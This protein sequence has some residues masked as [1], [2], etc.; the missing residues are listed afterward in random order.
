MTG[1][2]EKRVDHEHHFFGSLAPNMSVGGDPFTLLV[3]LLNQGKRL[4][5]EVD[6]LIQVAI[7]IVIL[8]VA[9]RGSLLGMV[10]GLAGLVA[11]KLAVL[12]GFVALGGGV[13][14]ADLQAGDA[15]TL[16]PDVLANE[17]RELD[18]SGK[19]AYLY[20]FPE[21]FHLLRNVL[22]LKSFAP[23][24][25]DD[26]L[27]A[28]SHYAEL[29]HFIQGTDNL[30]SATELFRQAEE[31]ARALLNAYSALALS[32]APVSTDPV[33]RLV[34]HDTLKTLRMVLKRDMSELAAVCRRFAELD[35]GKDAPIRLPD[36]P[37]PF[38]SGPDRTLF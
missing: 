22:V 2:A 4:A 12:D 5:T 9:T 19:H 20:A 6:P 30:D 18:P 16:Y 28:T 25:F 11:L 1:T 8:T 32:G 23:V 13:G 34:F 17:L 24:A 26:L 35:P 7:A 33:L 31:R 38:E 10:A 3:L 29:S 27:A 14:T 21:A 36:V 15:D 37:R